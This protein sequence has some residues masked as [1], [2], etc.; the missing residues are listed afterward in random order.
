MSFAS[1]MEEVAELS[2]LSYGCYQLTFTNG[3]KDP[4]HIRHVA[5]KLDQ[6]QEYGNYGRASQFM[7][8]FS[9]I[10][11]YLKVRDIPYKLH[12]T[13]SQNNPV[14]FNIECFIQFIKY[15]RYLNHN[16]FLEE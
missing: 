4:V 7:Y 10:C 12:Y 11:D 9:E 5:G 6:I 1:Q 15:Y 16:Q 2:S 13:Y 3:I 8:I 14:R